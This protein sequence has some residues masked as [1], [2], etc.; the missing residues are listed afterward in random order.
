MVLIV[1][2]VEA[3][4]TPDRTADSPAGGQHR[5]SRRDCWKNPM[6]TGAKKCDNGR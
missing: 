5:E 1:T 3:Q 4:P 6:F 2:F